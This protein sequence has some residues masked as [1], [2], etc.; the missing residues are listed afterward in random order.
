MEEKVRCK[1]LFGEYK[2]ESPDFIEVDTENSLIITKHSSE[3]NKLRIWTL[4]TYS[5]IWVIEDQSICE[6]KISLGFLLLI[7]EVNQTFLPLAVLDLHTGKISLQINIQNSGKLELLEVLGNT[8][9]IKEK[10]E[11]LKLF[12]VFQ[13]KLIKIDREIFGEAIIF[14]HRQHRFISIN[15]SHLFLY[16]SNCEIINT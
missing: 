3:G 4:S 1:I 9:I 6:F 14:M 8:I 7:G 13:N 16:N 2:M 12:D 11:I 10:G 15:D 5:L